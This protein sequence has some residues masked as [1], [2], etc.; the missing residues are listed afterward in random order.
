MAGLLF[1][2]IDPPSANLSADRLRSG[3]FW[4]SRRP[5]KPIPPPPGP[6]RTRPAVLLGREGDSCQLGGDKSHNGKGL[7]T[8][9]P[10]QTDSPFATVRSTP[11][12]FGRRCLAERA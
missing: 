7:R 11:A 5:L 8:P 9:P 2:P 3:P 6:V 4:P 10:P 12:A 1:F